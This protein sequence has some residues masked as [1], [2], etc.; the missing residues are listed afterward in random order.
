[1]FWFKIY[2]FHQDSRLLALVELDTMM[3]ASTVGKLMVLPSFLP[4]EEE[5]RQNYHG[6]QENKQKDGAAYGAYESTCQGCHQ[7]TYGQLSRRVLSVV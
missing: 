6:Q 4:E 5:L 1:M 2:L 7:T 3:G